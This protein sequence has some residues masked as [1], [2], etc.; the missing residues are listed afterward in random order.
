MN[1]RAFIRLVGG[2]AA[3]WPL[4]AGAQ[5]AMPVIGLLHH[6]FTGSKPGSSLFPSRSR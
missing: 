6:H 4:V 1:R 2:V 3:T 5:Q